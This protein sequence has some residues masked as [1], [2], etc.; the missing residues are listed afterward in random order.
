MS[1]ANAW[2]K[3]K[4]ERD[5]DTDVATWLEVPWLVLLVRKFFGPIVRG[6]AETLVAEADLSLVAL[7]LEP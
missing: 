2:S 5:L 3:A 7:L 6:K 4:A 1:A